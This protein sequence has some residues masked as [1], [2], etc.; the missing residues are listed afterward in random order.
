MSEPSMQLAIRHKIFTKYLPHTSAMKRLKCGCG[1]RFASIQA[2]AK[3]GVGGPQF[4]C[5]ACGNWIRNAP[6]Y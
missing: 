3:H 1:E 4:Q 5:I 6:R 2:R